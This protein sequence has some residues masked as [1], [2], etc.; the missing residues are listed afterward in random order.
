MLNNE[1][2]EFNK[3]LKELSIENFPIYAELANC[4]LLK[5]DYYKNDTLKSEQ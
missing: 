4:D 1:F 2:W 5:Q 3:D